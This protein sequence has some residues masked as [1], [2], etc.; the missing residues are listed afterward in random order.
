MKEEDSCVAKVNFYIKMETL[1]LL[2]L[3]AFTREAPSKNDCVSV[4][5]ICQH[6]LLLGALVLFCL[7]FVRVCVCVCCVWMHVWCFVVVQGVH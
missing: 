2:I 5:L 7:L 3:L 1:I 6:P 4:R